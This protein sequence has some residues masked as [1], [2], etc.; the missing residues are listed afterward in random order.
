MIMHKTVSL[1]DQVFE[2]LESD[3][4]TGKYPRGSVLTELSLCED[5]GVSRTP[6]REAIRRL[7]QEHI[8]ESQGKGMLV[9]SLTEEDA[10][11]IYTIRKRIE[12]LAAAG[13][14]VHAT[15]EEIQDLREVIELQQFYTDKHDSE[16]VKTLDSDF[17]SKIYRYSGSA[18]FYDTLMPLHKKIQKFRKTSLESGNRAAVSTAEHR[19]VFEAIVSRDPEAA[20]MMMYEHVK[21][22]SAS[23]DEQLARKKKAEGSVQQ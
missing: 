7:E 9:L 20:E 18:I 19:R 22:A 3:I 1:A 10:Q 15:D 17:H 5:L 8:I 12:G 21:N 23:L 16:K 11:V 14:A 4:L 2:R 6:V 13:C